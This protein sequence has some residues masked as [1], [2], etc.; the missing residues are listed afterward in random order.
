M[1]ANIKTKGASTTDVSQILIRYFMQWGIFTIMLEKQF[2]SIPLIV[3]KISR[4][5]IS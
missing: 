4:F 1:A 2:Y 5:I 3:F